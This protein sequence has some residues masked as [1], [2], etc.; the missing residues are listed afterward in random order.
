MIW[1]GY[2]CVLLITFALCLGIERSLDYWSRRISVGTL[3]LQ[4]ARGA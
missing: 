2:A 4:W 1:L 3:Y